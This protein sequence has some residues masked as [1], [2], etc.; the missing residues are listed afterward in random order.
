MSHPKSP[1]DRVG[2]MVWV[3]RM[4]DKARK[5]QTGELHPDYHANLGK[6]HDARCCNFLKVEYSG[7]REQ[8]ALGADD[9]ELREWCFVNGREPDAFDIE[10]W[11]AYMTKLGHRDENPGFAEFIA[12][13]KKAYGIEAR[14]DLVTFFHLIEHDEGRLA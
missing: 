3:A 9:D 10:V 14:D 8:I 2:D 6:G 11:N 4:F 1:H 7:V 5:M 13:R 12:E